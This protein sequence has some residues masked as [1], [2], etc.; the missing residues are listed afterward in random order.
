M[1]RGEYVEDLRLSKLS[2]KY[3]KEQLTELAAAR[4]AQ[5]I[6]A[7]GRVANMPG[8]VGEHAKT[9]LAALRKQN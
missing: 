3:T 2:D 8:A 1:A 9:L 4:R 6:D 7:L 5:V